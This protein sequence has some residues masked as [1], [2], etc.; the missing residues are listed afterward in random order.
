MNTVRFVKPQQT[1]PVPSRMPVV[2]RSVFE[3]RVER[4][5][6]DW[7]TLILVTLASFILHGFVLGVCALVVFDRDVVEEI[8]TTLAFQE[9]IE[10]EPIIEQSLVQPETLDPNQPSP[11]P[12][13]MANASR[14]LAESPALAELDINDLE[15]SFVIEDIHGLGANIKPGDHF[16]G[17]SAAIKAALVRKFGGNDAS[18]QAVASGLKWLASRQLKDGSWSFDH[19]ECAACDGGGC[20]QAGSFRRCR[21][22]ATALALLAFL[23]GG[24][25]HQQGDYQ[26]VVKS[27]LE[28]LLRGGTVTETGMDFRDK[29]G[30]GNLYVHGLAAIAL[31]E[32]AALTKDPRYYKPAFQAVKFIVAAQDPKGGGWRYGPRDPGDTSVVGW[33]IMALKSAQNSRM[34]IPPLTFRLADKFLDRVQADKGAVYGYM[35]APKTP[36]EAPPPMTAVGLLCRM[37]MGWDKKNPHLARGV[38]FL[39]QARPSPNNMYYNYYATQ[40]LHHWGGDEWKRWNDV[41]RDHLIRT[42]V[43]DGVEAGSWNITDPHGGPG[44]RLYQTCLCV[45]TLE[46]YYRHLPIYRRDK[47]KI[48]F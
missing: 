4:P 9:T 17:R 23:G 32:T 11:D 33:Q 8:F 15:P 39:D 44:G 36:G 28:A 10:H 16:S 1:Q 48:E 5:R 13:M 45:M 27:G 26:P 7:G 19:T 2:P 18:E 42:Q 3:D 31:C 47:V 6:T 21:N 37:Y 40:V 41:M 14:L 38:A 34:K 24:H 43:A 35:I 25:T 30:E 22:G 20:T 29:S 46:V 12:L